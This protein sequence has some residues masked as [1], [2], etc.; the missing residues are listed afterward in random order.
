MQTLITLKPD[1]SALS[2]NRVIR[3]A[4]VIPT[5]SEFS[6]GRHETEFV[7]T[8]RNQLFI[9]R[10]TILATSIEYNCFTGRAF[11]EVILSISETSELNL[12]TVRRRLKEEGAW[13]SNKSLV[14]QFSKFVGTP[15]IRS[16]Y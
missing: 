11:H 7:Q 10:E 2:R 3:I 5:C 12:T 15:H 14:L 8:I 16:S 9:I 4:A 6:I 1:D 13:R